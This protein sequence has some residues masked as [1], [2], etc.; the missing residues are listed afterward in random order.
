MAVKTPLTFKMCL[1]KARRKFNNFFVNKILELLHAYPV[2]K[3]TKEGKPFW[4]LPKRPPHT[5]EFDPLNEVHAIFISSY[6]CLHA[7]LYKLDIQSDGAEFLDENKN[8][9]SKESRLK[10]AK[11]VADM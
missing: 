3:L 6:A 5:I 1:E 4:S 10:M 8:P 7:N 2:D 9:R 11:Y